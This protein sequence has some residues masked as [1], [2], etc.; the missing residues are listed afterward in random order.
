MHYDTNASLIRTSTHLQLL[1]QMAFQCLYLIQHI[2]AAM[3]V[4]WKNHRCFCSAGCSNVHTVS[5]S[6]ERTHF[7]TESILPEMCCAF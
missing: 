1:N 2:I 7:L 3:L 5:C 4:P 6:T